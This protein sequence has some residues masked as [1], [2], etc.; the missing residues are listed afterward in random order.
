MNIARARERGT[1]IARDLSDL[2]PD[3]LW[4]AEASVEQVERDLME[5]A[6][7]D[8][9]GTIGTALRD[10]A[11]ALAV[12]RDGIAEAPAEILADRAMDRD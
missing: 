4:R 1:C 12:I 3:V 8:P 5:M 9:T 2:V 11:S 10:I 6:A 7:D